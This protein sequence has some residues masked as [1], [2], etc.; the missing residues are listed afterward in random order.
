M[1]RH[2]F[3]CALVLFPC[4]AASQEQSKLAHVVRASGEATVTAEPDRA[5]ISIG[6]ISQAPTAQEASSQNATQ[7]TRVLDAVRRVLGSGGEV[8]TSGYYIGPDYQYPKTGGSPKIVGYRAN[9]TVQVTV[10]DLTLVGK[11]IDA[12]TSSGANNINNIAFSLRNDDAVR[13]Q[14]LAEAAGKARGNAEAI[15]RALNLHVV[16]VLEAQTSE[17]PI[18]RPLMMPM[19]QQAMMAKAEVPTPI[20]PG[21]LDI[22]ASVTVTLQVQ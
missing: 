11:V 17:S 2:R 1:M 3:L 14:A 8:K 20:E 5:Q 13:A 7:T 21:T 6:V 18:I 19:A 16:G 9:N 10:N 12:A 4:L 22:H 15:A